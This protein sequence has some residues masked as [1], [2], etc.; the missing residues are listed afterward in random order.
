MSKNDHL[1][2]GALEAKKKVSSSLSRCHVKKWSSSLRCLRSPKK[3]NHHWTK[4]MPKMIAIIEGLQNKKKVSSALNRFYV[5]NDHY[6]RG[7]SK[8]LQKK[9]TTHN[10]IAS[11][12]NRFHV[13]N[14][15]YH[16]S[17]SKTHRK[18]SIFFGHYSPHHHQ[19][20]LNLKFWK[21]NWI[22]LL[23]IGF[24]LKKLKFI[25]SKNGLF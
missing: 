4:C 3:D 17:A 20:S 13:K 7:G 6:H 25:L 10:K 1:H 16:R 23:K 9:S 19:L 18:F 14:D 22:F 15:H 8:R 12:L 5:K 2:W 11:W 24:P 21:K